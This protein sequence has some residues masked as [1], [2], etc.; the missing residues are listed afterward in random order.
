MAIVWLRYCDLRGWHW[1]MKTAVYEESECFRFVI[2][3]LQ[4]DFFGRS[5]TMHLQLRLPY[6]NDDQYESGNKRVLEPSGLVL[7]SKSLCP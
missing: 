4:L 7:N 2:C 3:L 5:K 6:P 1:S